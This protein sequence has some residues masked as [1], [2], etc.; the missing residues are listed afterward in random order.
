MSR[1]NGS[2]FRSMKQQ[3]P[4]TQQQLDVLFKAIND[5]ANYTADVE[6]K[7]EFVLRQIRLGRVKPGAIVGANGKMPVEQCS[8]LQLFEEQRDV[9]AEQLLAER[10]AER[11]AYH[12]TLRAEQAAGASGDRT[13]QGAGTG[14]GAGVEAGEGDGAHADRPT[15]P[16]L[17]ILPGG[18]GSES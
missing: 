2:P 16:S 18:K 11:E 14:E 9:F 13:S 17:I 3:H 7:V 1:K 10:Q 5:L 4:P 12:E 8:L 6:L 15:G